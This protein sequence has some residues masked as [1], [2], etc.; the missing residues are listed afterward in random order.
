M[1]QYR[2]EMIFGS[3]RHIDI[4]VILCLETVEKFFFSLLFIKIR[5]LTLPIC[6]KQRHMA[7]I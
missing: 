7:P 2:R 3:I 1:I 5:V 6:H 4:I